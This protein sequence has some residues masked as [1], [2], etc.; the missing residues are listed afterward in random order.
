MFK[1]Y[2]ETEKAPA[3]LVFKMSYEIQSMTYMRTGQVLDF[4][5]EQDSVRVLLPPGNIGL[6]GLMADGYELK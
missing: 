5:R 2:A 4:V 3:Q 6:N 1:L